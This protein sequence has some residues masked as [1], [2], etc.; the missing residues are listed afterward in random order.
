MIEIK[1]IIFKMFYLSL[2]FF[3]Q[4]P[5]IAE[6]QELG[7]ENFVDTSHEFNSI[8]YKLGPGDKLRINVYKL[9][10]FGGEFDILPD[11]TINLQRIPPI[12]IK[13]LSL[14]EAERK[15]KIS[16][17]K[18]L[19]N[20][21]VHIKLVFQRPIRV[22]I[23]GEVQMPGLYTMG[24]KEVNSLLNSSQDKLIDINSEGIP[25]LI[26]AIQKAGGI[27]LNGNLREV[28]L[29]RKVNDS[30]DIRIK[31][32]NFWESLSNG[33]NLENPYLFDGDYINVPRVK[34]I[35]DSEILKMSKSSFSPAII[36]VNILGEV[37]SPGVKKIRSNLTL[38]Q[39][40]LFAG[41]TTSRTNRSKIRLIRLNS[42]GS[43]KSEF[44][45][46]SEDTKMSNKD[47]PLIRD[48]DVVIVGKNAY[49]AFTDGVKTLVSPFNPIV[50]GAAFIKLISD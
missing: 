23:T 7:S 49:S 5:L 1:K 17:E 14:A 31:E 47:N 24:N 16:L 29:V 43:V 22:N 9:S 15:I 37:K 12:N 20:P 36:R 21:I 50:N 27:T 25:T 28:T 13:G 44:Y 33:K 4:S 35:N 10:Q 39:A 48:G 26:G 38:S 32:F 41:G 2:I 40:I 3:F 45:K 6:I 8:T 18:V 30:G 19:V 34:K 46:F 42:N 11:G